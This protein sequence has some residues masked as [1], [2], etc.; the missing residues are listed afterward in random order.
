LNPNGT[1][2]VTPILNRITFSY[3]GNTPTFLNR[4]SFTLPNVPNGLG[5][6]ERNNFG[7]IAITSAGLLFGVTNAD[8]NATGRLFRLNLTTLTETA[9][10]NSYQQI[11]GDI[12]QGG[13]QTGFSPLYDI[14]YANNANN[15]NWVTIN[16]SNGDL[17]NFNQ[18]PPNGALQYN[19]GPFFDVSDSAT[20]VRI[21]GPLPLLGAAAA[22]GW[23]RKLR[24]R[25]KAAVEVKIPG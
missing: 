23:S 4:Q 9:I 1:G 21:P 11:D 18:L 12:G 19:S 13:L 22:F 14:L 20:L 7:D 5:S 8:T 10:N 25:V 24:K 17:T 16:T 3:T 2:N 6:N 15:G